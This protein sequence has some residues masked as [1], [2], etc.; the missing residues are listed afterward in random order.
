MKARVRAPLKTTRDVANFLST[1]CRE[2][3]AGKISP[4][5]LAQWAS[6]LQVL[7]KMREGDVSERLDMI[8]AALKSRQNLGVMR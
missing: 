2:A 1:L 4:G 8:E 3:R 7:G 5:Q 6:A